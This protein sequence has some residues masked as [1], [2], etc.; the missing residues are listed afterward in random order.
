M[1]MVA[2][3]IIWVLGAAGVGLT[4]LLCHLRMSQVSLRWGPGGTA[5]PHTAPGPCTSPPTLGPLAS[6]SLSCARQCCCLRCSVSGQKAQW[7]D[8]DDAL[9]PWTNPGPLVLPASSLSH[10]RCQGGQQSSSNDS[11]ARLQGFKMHCMTM[12]S[13]GRLAA[14]PR[15]Y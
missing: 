12:L 8:P 4:H 11:R 1:T 6:S 2:L 10:L 13:F 5:P 3:K 14:G 7:I 15:R 9:E